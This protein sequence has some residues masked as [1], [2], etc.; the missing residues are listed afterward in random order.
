MQQYFCDPDF[1]VFYS[2]KNTFSAN[3]PTAP[4]PGIGQLIFQLFVGESVDAYKS[5]DLHRSPKLADKF[6][7]PLIG[8]FQNNLPKVAVG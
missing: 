3:W 5:P 7:K 2:P 4:D 1:R 8:F 6:N